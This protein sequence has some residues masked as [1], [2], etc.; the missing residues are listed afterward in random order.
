MA[1]PLTLI[2]KTVTDSKRPVVISGVT[3]GLGRALARRFAGLGYPVAGCGR[4][5]HALAELRGELG[6]SHCFDRLDVTDAESVADWADRVHRDLGA[7]GL[8]IASAGLINAP[9]PAWEVPPTEFDAVLRANVVGVYT[10]TR[11][12]L[13][14][15]VDGG[16]LINL[17]S[18]WGR[19]P[20]GML[21][22]YTASK[23]AVEGF[24]RAV[25][26]EAAQ[27]RPGIRVVALDPGGGVDTDMLAICL[28]E[29]H[30]QYPS[31]DEWAKIAVD[32]LV[33]QLPVGVSLT[34]I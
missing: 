4:S 5:V 8:V 18:G 11:A 2:R 31:P 25:A 32:Y 30:H 34:V 22:T 14:R 10:M 12:F 23:F 29:E 28:P 33:R 20:R 17:S 1:G 6:E 19:N 26:H 15:I 9:A 24:T 3:K 16:A 27:L 7:P 13:P 21:A